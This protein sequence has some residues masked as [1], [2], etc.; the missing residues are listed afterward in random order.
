MDIKNL[1]SWYANVLNARSLK[2][3]KDL[4]VKHCPTK[5]IC[6]N[7]GGQKKEADGLSDDQKEKQ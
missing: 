6:G 7:T 5:A 1:S 3:G 4:S 2:H